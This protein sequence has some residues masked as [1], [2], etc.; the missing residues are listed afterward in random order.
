MAEAMWSSPCVLSDLQGVPL[1]ALLSGCQPHSGARR[2]GAVGVTESHLFR[3]EESGEP[4][5]HPSKKS[6]S[7]L[8]VPPPGVDLGGCPGDPDLTLLSHLPLR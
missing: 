3:C 7:L 8:L 2:E 4:P 6:G 1:R 5:R